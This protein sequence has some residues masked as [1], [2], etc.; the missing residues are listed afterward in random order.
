MA[1]RRRRNEGGR[2][3]IRP[4]PQDGYPKDRQQAH[5]TAILYGNLR[6]EIVSN[7]GAR[8]QRVGLRQPRVICSP[9]AGPRRCGNP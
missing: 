7:A 6:A 1:S 2:L 4:Q 3:E 9:L 5:V 8:I